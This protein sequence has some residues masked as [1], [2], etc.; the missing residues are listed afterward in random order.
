MKYYKIAPKLNND[1]GRISSSASVDNLP[2]LENEFE[3]IRYGEIVESF[4]IIDSF[5]LESFDDEKYWEYQLNDIHSFIGK[6]K[7]IT[8]WFISEKLKKLFSDLKISQP[9]YFYSGKLLYHDE[10]YKYFIF[11]FL[12]K[13]I[14]KELTSYIDFSKSEFINPATEE[15][16]FFNDIDHYAE[17]S[18]ELYFEKDTDFVKK[19]IVLKDD[20][21]F[22]PMQSFFKDN[23]AS[24]RLK[25]LIKEN[26]ITGFEFS[27][28]DYEVVVEVDK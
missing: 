24:E 14:Y 3:K 23:I 16:H 28:L 8:G 17:K 19:K 25:Q 18:E 10:I 15:L 2:G 27:E 5:Y 21:D 20:L 9:H 11:Q 1:N 12:G 4:P 26:E 6:A 7:V 22:F 13:D